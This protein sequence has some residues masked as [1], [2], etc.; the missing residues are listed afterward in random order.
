MLARKVTDLAICR[1]LL[2]AWG[3]LAANVRI[4]MGLGA[5]AVAISR[6]G[7]VVNVIDWRSTQYEPRKSRGTTQKKDNEA[8]GLRTERP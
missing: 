2:V 6:H 4:K 1:I 7:L 5:G 8:K 3:C